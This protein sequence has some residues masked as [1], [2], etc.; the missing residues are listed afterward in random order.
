MNKICT[1]VIAIVIT[2]SIPLINITLNINKTYSTPTTNSSVIFY[3]IFKGVCSV[4]L[5][6]ITSNLSITANYLNFY[7]TP[8][9]SSQKF[10]F[11][12]I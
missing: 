12:Y 9:L 5:L 8:Q 10:I 3:F 4:Y 1:F 7:Y 11:P 6:N 2:T